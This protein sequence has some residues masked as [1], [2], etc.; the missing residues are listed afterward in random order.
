M[1]EDRARLQTAL[2]AAA[3]LFIASALSCAPRTMPPHWESVEIP[4]DAE[5]KGMWFA[6]SLNGWIT[7]GGYLIDGGIVGR[8]RDGGRTWRFQSGVLP[9]GGTAFNLNRVQFRDTLRGCAVGYGGIVLVTNDGG[10]G[11]RPVRYGR[12][13]ADALFDIQFLDASNAWASGPASVVRTDD[14]GESWRPLVFGT[15]ENGYLSANAIH[16]ID[17]EHGWLV[18]HGG[19]LMRSGDGGLAW[20][21]VPLPLRAGERPTLWD[22]TFSDASNG[23]VVGE[24]GSIF[25]TADGGMTWT[26]QERGV[27][28]VRVPGKNEPPRPHEV[29]PDLETKPDR[30]SLSAVQFVDSNH[31][32]AIGYYADV[33]ESVILRTSDG[34]VTWRVERVVP[35][36]MLRALFMLD[37]SH[38]WAAGDRA[39]TAPQVV[40]RYVDAER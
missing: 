13:G 1:V 35:G 14:G 24:E 28:I 2:L 10:E 12:S 11:W 5:F 25:H 32:C 29:I 7:G 16:F 6:D 31:G 22:V 34:G 30:L 8:T 33:A 21:S 19:S 27:P 26:R 3:L 17:L 18:G 38:A 4:T 36:E 37:A 20:A 9:G 40:L 39:R 23:W 15:S